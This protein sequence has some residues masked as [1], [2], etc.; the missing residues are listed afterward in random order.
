MQATNNQEIKQ[1]KIRKSYRI[2]PSLVKFMA[3]YGE[4]KRWGETTIIEYALEKL[5]ENEGYLIEKTE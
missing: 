5:A 2:N 4:N 3:V 1:E